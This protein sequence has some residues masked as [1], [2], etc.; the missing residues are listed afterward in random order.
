MAF[1]Y[2]LQSQTSGRC[3]IGSTNDLSRRLAEHHGNH[4]PSTRG[5]GPWSLVYQETLPTL[6]EARRRELVIKRWQSARLIEKL[7]DSRK[8]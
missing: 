1:V 8:G 5:R 3:Y 6:T 2:I 7:I 4:S